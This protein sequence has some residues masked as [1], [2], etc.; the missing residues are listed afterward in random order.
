MRRPALPKLGGA[1][2][3]LP[4]PDQAQFGMKTILLVDD[5][6]Q[7]REFFVFALRRSGYDVIEA[8]SGAVALEMAR[9]YLPDLIVSDINMP[10]GDGQ[11]LLHDVRH[12][13]E[14]KSR[15]VVL[16]TGNPELFARRQI[17]E[18]GADDFLLKPVSLQEFLS[19][20][21]ARFNRASL[22]W[23]AEDLVAS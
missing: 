12:D 5:D 17:M 23:P 20:V 18:K 13:P 21:K 7:V 19:C 14:L 9:H 4:S 22:T 6:E 16:I 15:Q 3:K 2:H 8:D 10:G 11:S 1:K